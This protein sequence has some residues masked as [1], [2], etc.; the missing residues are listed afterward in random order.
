MKLCYHRMDKWSATVGQ[1]DRG[2]TGQA[3][4]LG[5]FWEGIVLGN[6]YTGWL[7]GW[8]ANNEVC[9]FNLETFAVLIITITTLPI[10]RAIVSGGE[11]TRG[12]KL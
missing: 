6:V 2:E 1:T 9:E 3:T 10:Q 5:S 8:L 12:P 4:S 11:G 7:A